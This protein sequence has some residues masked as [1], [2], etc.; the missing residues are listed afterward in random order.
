MPLFETTLEEECRELRESVLDSLDRQSDVAAEAA[1][2]YLLHHLAEN[3][4]VRQA[5]HTA[6]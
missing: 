5:R 4:P 6:A 2:A 1:C 3:Y